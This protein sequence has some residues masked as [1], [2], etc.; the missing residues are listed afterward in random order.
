M[1]TEGRLCGT[2]EVVRCYS[3]GSVL[4]FCSCEVGPCYSARY[5]GN[6]FRKF[7]VGL[8]TV[9]EV[10]SLWFGGKFG[11]WL[12]TVLL[13]A[14]AGCNAWCDWRSGLEW[15]SGLSQGWAVCGNLEL[16]A[17]KAMDSRAM[18][19]I[20]EAALQVTSAVH[21]WDGGE[22]TAEGVTAWISERL[23]AYEAAIAALLAVEGVRTAENSLRLYDVAIEQL[24]LAGAQAGVLNS[25]AAEKAVRDRAQDEAQRISEAGT[26]LSLNRDVYAALSAIDLSGAENG[27][28]EATRHYVQRTLLSYRLAGVDKDD[29]TRKHLRGLHEKAT[30]LSLEFSRNIQEGGKTVL[31]EDEAELDGLPAD[32]LA[33]HTPNCDG[34]FVLSTDQP[35][36][37]PV[38]TFAKSDA[39][40]ERMFLAYNTRAYPVNSQILLDL[41][42]TRQ[43]I[44]TLLGFSSWANLA[45]ADQ[46]MGSA[47][48]VRKFIARLEEASRGGAEREYGMV[49]EFAR[50]QQPDLKG[51]ECG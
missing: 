25:V 3:A 34:Q 38:M 7:G 6:I 48:N 11:K 12:W 50:A 46:M 36:M 40:R 29:A 22:L 43:E 19:G 28:S 47:D 13:F 51:H 27:T 35:D 18:S 37:Q 16:E 14:A 15:V 5:A 8:P 23:K 4:F 21:V 17:G 31:V 9:L 30:R 49:L 20:E 26:A 10:H 1:N 41:L 33:R 24:S 45:T 2:T 42:A 39:L 44:A 32:Y